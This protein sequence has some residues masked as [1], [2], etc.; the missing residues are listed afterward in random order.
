MTTKG[1]WSSE[2]I[3][4]KI[5]IKEKNELQELLIGDDRMG[6]AVSILWPTFSK[7]K[8]DRQPTISGDTS[9]RRTNKQGQTNLRKTTS[10][11]AYHYPMMHTNWEAI[12]NDTSRLHINRQETTHLVWFDFDQNQ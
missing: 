10:Q 11:P 6:S 5:I 8:L 7:F 12:D 9:D 4:S 2:G 3:V 1:K